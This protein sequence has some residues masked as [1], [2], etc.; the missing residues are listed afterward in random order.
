ML[1]RRYPLQD[2]PAAVFSIMTLAPD[3]EKQHDEVQR[4]LWHTAP[5]KLP[6]RNAEP[7]AVQWV[8][9]GRYTSVQYH[10]PTSCNCKGGHTFDAAVFAQGRLLAL[11]SWMAKR[12]EHVTF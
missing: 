10:L 11:G 5:A 9:G 8:E 2:D 7:A 1:N 3:N 12:N 4:K 6:R